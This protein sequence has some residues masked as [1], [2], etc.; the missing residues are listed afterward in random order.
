MEQCRYVL[1]ESNVGE[2]ICFGIAAVIYYDGCAAI[3]QTY[4]DLCAE[5]TTV[6]NFVHKC[7]TKRLS[8]CHLQDT[9]DDFL[10]NL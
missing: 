10:A 2:R 9:V 4:A 1:F 6:E 7:N 8:L 5:R 3:L